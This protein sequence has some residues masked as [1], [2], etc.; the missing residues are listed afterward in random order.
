MGKAQGKLRATS[1][2]LAWTQS[3]D[4][5]KPE[6][7]PDLALSSTSERTEAQREVMCPKVTHMIQDKDLDP[8]FLSQMLLLFHCAA[9]FSQPP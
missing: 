9:K 1:S 3:I 5:N 6:V 8:G 2:W 4:Q 7:S